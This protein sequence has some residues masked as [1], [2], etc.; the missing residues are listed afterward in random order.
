[1][2]RTLR[3]AVLPNGAVGPA[4]GGQPRCAL[5]VLPSSASR[6]AQC[7]SPTEFDGSLLQPATRVLWRPFFTDR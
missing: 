1:M 4:Q 7:R 2:I 6:A 5:S 3:P